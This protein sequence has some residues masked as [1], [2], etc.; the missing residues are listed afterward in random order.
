MLSIFLYHK[1]SSDAIYFTSISVFRCYLFFPFSHIKH[2]L[3]M[4]SILKK[5]IFS[6]L[7]TNKTFLIHKI[8]KIQDKKLRIRD[9]LEKFISQNVPVIPDNLMEPITSKALLWQIFVWLFL[10]LKLSIHFILTFIL[11]QSRKK[12]INLRKNRKKGQKKHFVFNL[13]S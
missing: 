4:P 12:K 7:F 10:T 11:D 1:L 8:K 9:P 3:L 6:V 5:G 2:C 13:T